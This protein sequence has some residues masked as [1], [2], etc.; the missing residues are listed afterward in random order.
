M[1][2][3]GELAPTAEREPVHR[4]DR[5]LWRCLIA[6]KDVLSALRERLRRDRPMILELGDVGP[7]DERAPRA[8]ENDAADFRI[9]SRRINRV[10]ELGD[11]AVVERVQL[12]GAIDSYRRDPVGDA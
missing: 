12:V 11:D 1:T 3:H 8:G 5:R 6:T 9:F 7:G 4:G 10:P 2:R